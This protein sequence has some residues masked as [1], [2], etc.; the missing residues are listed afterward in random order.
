MNCDHCVHTGLCMYEE[1]ARKYE[2]RIGKDKD[3]PAL[4]DILIKCKKFNQKIL[5]H[6]KKVESVK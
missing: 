1:G 4:I 5:I 6:P 2:E 3:K